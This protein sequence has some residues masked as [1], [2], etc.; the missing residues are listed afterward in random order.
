[1]VRNVVSV[2]VVVMVCIAGCSRLGE[3]VWIR[4][5]SALTWP[6]RDALRIGYLGRIASENDL[7]PDKPL[8]GL[9][10]LR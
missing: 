7:R 2:I 6:S 8:Y 3:P 1:M 10:L 9:I 4:D 5:G